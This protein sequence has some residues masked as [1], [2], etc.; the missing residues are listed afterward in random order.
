MK[1]K[2]V[3]LEW[4]KKVEAY[5]STTFQ[6]AISIVH[7]EYKRRFDQNYNFDYSVDNF[8][9]EYGS[10]LTLVLSSVEIEIADYL[11]EYAELGV[12]IHCSEILRLYQVLISWLVDSRAVLNN[13]QSPNGMLWGDVDSNSV[14]S[15]IFEM[16]DVLALM[17]LLVIRLF[18]SSKRN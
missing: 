18:T 8:P 14:Q 3:S 17:N 15:I 9:F 6:N 1:V 13:Q 10:D 12:D 2:D 5:I 7:S 11:I 16:E 4:K